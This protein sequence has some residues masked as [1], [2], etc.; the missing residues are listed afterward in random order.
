MA[1]KEAESYQNIISGIIYDQAPMLIIFLDLE[2]IITYAN[3]KSY[4]IL[5]YSQNELIGK[6]FVQRF[7]PEPSRAEANIHVTKTLSSETTD[8]I[9]FGSPVLTKDG[10][11]KIILWNLILVTD[12]KGKVTGQLLTGND[13]TKRRRYLTSL[14]KCLDLLD[15]NDEDIPFQ[16]LT[17][18]L[19]KVS[20][21]SRASIYMVDQDSRKSLS[22]RKISEWCAEG[23]TSTFKGSKSQTIPINNLGRS[24]VKILTDGEIINKNVDELPVSEQKYYLERDVK[25]ILVIPVKANNTLIALTVLENCISN[26]KWSNNEQDFIEKSVKSLEQKIITQQILSRLKNENRRFQMTMDAFDALVYIVDFYTYELLFINKKG[27][28]SWQGMPGQT[29]YSV[30]QK[31]RTK[32][33]EFCTNH[34]FMENKISRNESHI[35]EYYNPENKN[36]YRNHE[37]AIQWT[38][39]RLVK[40]VVAIRITDQKKA[41]QALKISVDSYRGLF[42]N[43]PDAIY[44]QDKQG[45]FLDVNKSVVEM[46]GYKFD[47]YIGKTPQFLSAPGKNDLEKI[48]AKIELA[49]EGKPQIF[50]FWGLRKNGEIFPK[51]VRINAGVYFGENVIIAFAQDITDRKK[52]EQKILESEERF[53]MLSDITFE[54]IFIHDE[55]VII[56]GNS[57]LSNMLGYQTEE[58]IGKNIIDLVV[59]QKYH[60]KVKKHLKHKSEDPYEIMGRK[61][62]GTLIPLEIEAKQILLKGKEVRCVAIRNIS[63]RKKAELK[64]KK[65]ERV[66]KQTNKELNTFHYRSSHDLRGPL[67]TLLGLTSLA[68]IENNDP[69]INH[70]F[71]GIRNTVFQMMRTLKKLNDINALFNEKNKFSLVNC[72]EIIENIKLELVKIDPE[73]IVQ[74]IYA[75][76]IDNHIRSNKT[77]LTIILLYLMENS[78]IFRRNNIESFVRFTVSSEN[79]RIIFTIEDNG[80]GIP[81]NIRTKIFNMFFRGSDVSKGNGLGLYLVKKAIQS[82]SGTYHVYSRVDQYT[83]FVIVIPLK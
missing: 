52:A 19:G 78:I 7:I 57:S 77:L 48:K 51:E 62:D 60:E 82:L 47:E 29:C 18:I 45:V 36:W 13:I 75:C 70:Y 73:N 11:E 43:A 14:F 72:D 27:T 22:I 69:N 46:Y 76:K 61:K 17:N 59:P 16:E 63:E 37:K 20:E 2:G 54:G 30:I 3:Q 80:I 81:V 41:E 71:T 50:E 33:C 83:K 15:K 39:G 38:D 25:S 58:L 42:N 26:R 66:I 6:N 4:K 12:K 79:K 65:Q 74:K 5:G 40:V 24:W 44:I 35:W 55:G 64:L 23:F 9:S 32:P 21:S 34:L 68:E 53:K 28:E 67:T 1:K 56:D 10:N 8:D 31:S 49:Y